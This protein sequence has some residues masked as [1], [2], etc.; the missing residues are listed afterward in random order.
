MFVEQGDRD[1]R[2]TLLLSTESIVEDRLCDHFSQGL[3]T[4]L[5]RGEIIWLEQDKSYQIEVWLDQEN[6]D[7]HKDF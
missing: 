4:G 6:Q 7:V 1:A 3:L 2:C 5:L